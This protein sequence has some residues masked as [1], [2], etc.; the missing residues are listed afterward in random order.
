MDVLSAKPY[1]QRIR[2]RVLL[3]IVAAGLAA[4]GALAHGAAS[5][6]SGCD[7]TA[8]MW[9]AEDIAS[10][11]ATLVASIGNQGCSFS[12]SFVLDSPF[13]NLITQPLHGSG[14]AQTSPNTGFASVASRPERRT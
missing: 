5:R 8:L 3:S 12:F 1:G 11:S 13:S 10:L 6:T 9:P 2:A 4:A 14:P 7:V